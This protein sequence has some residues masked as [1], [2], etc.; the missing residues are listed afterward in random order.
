MWEAKAAPGRADELLAW[1]LAA[2]PAGQV[3]AAG[4]RVVLVVDLAESTGPAG[5][6]GPADPPAEL[7]ARP[8]HAWRFTRVR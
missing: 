8:V 4:D 7:L 1:L 5:P 2:A 6:A 3:F